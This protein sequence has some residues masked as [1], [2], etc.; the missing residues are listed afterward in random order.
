M[1]CVQ[2][3]ALLQERQMCGWQALAATQS[4]T[5]VGNQQRNHLI[6]GGAALVCYVYRAWKPAKNSRLSRPYFSPPTQDA[7][8]KSVTFAGLV[9]PSTRCCMRARQWVPLLQ[10]HPFTLPYHR[11]LLLQTSMLS[12][13]RKKVT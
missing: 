3:G 8:C 6:F 9:T 12:C 7:C 10:S 2:G 5:R 13:R 1:P 11:P 4:S